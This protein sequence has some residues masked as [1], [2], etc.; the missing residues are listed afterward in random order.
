MHG[1]STQHVMSKTPVPWC[2]VRN[3]YHSAMSQASF[4]FTNVVRERNDWS[5]QPR[6]G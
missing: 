6:R 2:V 1:W 3:A 5:C 4:G